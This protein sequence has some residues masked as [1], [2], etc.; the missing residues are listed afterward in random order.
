M[1]FK[2]K[3]VRPLAICVFRKGDRLLVGEG[4]DPAKRET[5]YRPLGGTISFGEHSQQAIAREIREELNVEVTNVR[6]LGTLE[7]IFTYDGRPGHEIVLVYEADFV[8]RSLYEK[9]TIQGIEDGNI[10]FKAVWKPLEE[11]ERGG[12][13]LYPEGLLELLTK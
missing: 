2:D 4:Y 5:F 8:D 12:S 11:F 13:P 9:A 10:P 6:F 1:P 3:R 7:N